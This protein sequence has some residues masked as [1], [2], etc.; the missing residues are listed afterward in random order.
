MAL[1]TQQVSVIRGTLYQASQ[2]GLIDQ[3]EHDL[4]NN[5]VISGN[6]GP[7]QNANGIAILHRIQAVYNN[8]AISA[9]LLELGNASTPSTPT[10]QPPTPSTPSVP[11]QPSQPSGPLPFSDSE[12]VT[13]RDINFAARRDYGLQPGQDLWDRLIAMSLAMQAKQ[14]WSDSQESHLLGMMAATPTGVWPANR[15]LLNRYAAA[16]G[17][18]I[19]TVAPPSGSLPVPSGPNPVPTQPTTPGPSLPTTWGPLDQAPTP[20]KSFASGPAFAKEVLEVLR[21]N[22]VVFGERVGFGEEPIQNTE[23][24]VTLFNGG[25]I[26]MNDSNFQ[27]DDEQQ[28]PAGVRPRHGNY[29]DIA[30]SDGGGRIMQY[31]WYWMN[32]VIRNT[33]NRKFTIRALFDS[34]GEACWSA[35]QHENGV[36]GPRGQI[37]YERIDYTR[38]E[39]H[40]SAFMPGW[41]VILKG[42]SVYG[43]NDLDLIQQK[44][45]AAFAQRGL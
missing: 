18:T 22:T 1:T 35:E 11:S 28:L 25:I 19:A 20:L 4:I 23:A 24:R 34:Q 36:P 6:F 17:A 14:Q 37:F 39:I 32:K 44:I 10:P 41:K 26:Q 3:N 30:N 31:G 21:N 9:L 42:S 12:I 2:G 16:I 45:D 13:L 5:A 27:N 38:K 29:L 8:S 7:I 43:A 15:A 33:I 40:L